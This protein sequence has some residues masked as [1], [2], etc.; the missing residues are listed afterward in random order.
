MSSSFPNGISSMKLKVSNFEQE[1]SSASL[2]GNS[3]K[4]TEQNILNALQSEDTINPSMAVT[5]NNAAFSSGTGT[6]N[7]E[8]A[9]TPYVP[10]SLLANGFTIKYTG[11]P[12]VVTSVTP[13][14][15]QANLRGTGAEWFAVVKQDMKV[16][17]TNYAKGIN[18]AVPVNALNFDGY[19]DGINYGLPALM[20]GSTGTQFR[21][22]STLECWFKH[23]GAPQDI[24]PTLMARNY[25]GG[26]NTDLSVFVLDMYNNKVRLYITTTSG[27]SSIESINTYA[28]STWH[29]A[30]VSYNGQIGE[31]KLYIDG[32]LDSSYT[33]AALGLLS[34][35]TNSLTNFR[36]GDS[37]TDWDQMGYRGSIAEVR[38]WNIIRTPTEIYNNYLKQLV[39]NENGLILYNRLDQGTANGNNSG[40]NTTT[41]NMITGGY[42]GT[43]QNFSLSGSISNWVS[44]PPLLGRYMWN[45]PNESSPVL[46][47][48][49]VTTLMT[50][51][52]NMFSGT[53]TFNQPINSWDTSNVTNMYGMFQNAIEFNQDISGW[54]VS[55]VTSYSNFKSGSALTTNNTPPAFR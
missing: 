40:I 27:D 7:V 34:D 8:V 1:I 23:P 53:T 52:S 28:D 46:F 24:Y 6:G 30:A 15:I 25:S 20:T 43:L 2:G 4:I 17:M 21:T 39:G 54:N 19:N 9:G 31:F 22:T 3:I 33:N 41:N 38:I 10:I 44:G 12:S 11:E 35:S 50:D 45:P 32:V 37:R 48:N 26:G 16:E 13:R 36:V 42:T 5:Y 47:N 14:F 51:M 55:L 49:I 18:N 29:H